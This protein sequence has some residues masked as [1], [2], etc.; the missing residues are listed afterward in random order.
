[1][2]AVEGGVPIFAR[3]RAQAADVLRGL[4]PGSVAGVIFI[5]AKPQPVL[6][7]LSANLAS[8][9]QGLANAEPTLEKGDPNAALALASNQIIT[10]FGQLVAG[11]FISADEYL[12]IVYRFAGEVAPESRPDAPAPAIAPPKG[13]AS[14]AG[15][16]V[17]TTTSDVRT[18]E[19]Q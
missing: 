18:D 19:P 10:A 9:H 7:A 5:G 15:I 17:D 13:T 8:L 4:E 14:Q 16:H 11:G 12:R 6:P 1:M 2:R 3:A